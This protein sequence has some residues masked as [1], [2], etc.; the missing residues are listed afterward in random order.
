MLTRE[1]YGLVNR[2]IP[3]LNSM[4]RLPAGSRNREL[5]KTRRDR[6]RTEKLASDHWPICAGL[7]LAIRRAS[8]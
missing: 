1:L 4:T 6:M 7:K 5:R 8:R 2:S 3:T